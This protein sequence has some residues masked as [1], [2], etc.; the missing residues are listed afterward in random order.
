MRVICCVHNSRLFGNIL[1]NPVGQTVSSI[2][3]NGKMR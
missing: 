2:F 3:H 1:T